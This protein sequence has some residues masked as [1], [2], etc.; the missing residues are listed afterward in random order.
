V[1]PEQLAVLKGAAL[2]HDHTARAEVLRQ[3][4]RQETEARTL[5]AV[6]TL[7]DTNQNARDMTPAQYRTF[8][9]K[10][11]RALRGLPPR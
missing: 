10:M 3:V 9:A 4:D 2:D 11:C 7:R 6:T 1:T 8:R 5:H